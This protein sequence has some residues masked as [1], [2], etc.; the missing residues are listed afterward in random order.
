MLYALLIEHGKPGDVYN[1]AAEEGVPIGR[2]TRTIAR[3]LGIDSEPVVYDVEAAFA[4]FGIS[5]AGYA[6]DQQMSGW[7]AMQELGW[8]PQH[9]DV[10]AV[11]G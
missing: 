3:R 10:F 11:I 8:D 7:K 1:G 6:L 9:R 2:M 4:D 5:A